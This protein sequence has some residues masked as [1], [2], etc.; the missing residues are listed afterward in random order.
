MNP[1]TVHVAAR[2]QPMP[3]LLFFIDCSHPRP[4]S[5]HPP[6]RLWPL[7]RL[8]PPPRSLPDSRRCRSASHDSGCH[9]PPLAGPR[10]PCSAVTGQRPFPTP[11]R[12]LS[13]PVPG[14]P[15]SKSLRISVP[16]LG[17]RVL[18]SLPI[19]FSGRVCRRLVFF[20]DVRE[21]FQLS[22]PAFGS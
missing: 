12:C 18:L 10:L 20:V 17:S 15:P 8:W 21:F 7:P 19:F 14:C 22:P 11:N 4:T 5:R 2:A 6:N 16:Y 3:T 9:R 1:M 13:S